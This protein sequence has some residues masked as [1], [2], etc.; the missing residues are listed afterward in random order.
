[1]Y[2]NYFPRPLTEMTPSVIN[3]YPISFTK[4]A[5]RRAAALFFPENFLGVDIGIPVMLD[6]GN[7][8]LI[9]IRC[10]IGPMDR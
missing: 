4:E 10:R 1:M 9:L 3:K 8:S 5:Y 2:S 6:D 7:Y